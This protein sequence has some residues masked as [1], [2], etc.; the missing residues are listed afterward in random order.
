MIETKGITLRQAAMELIKM[1]GVNS[2][3]SCQ[4]LLNDLDNICKTESLSEKVCN[5]LKTIIRTWWREQRRDE[6]ERL[7]SSTDRLQD[8][9]N[10][11]E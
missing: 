7:K 6:N 8:K 11:L 5:D 1:A 2:D 9:I 4:N 10:S 3:E